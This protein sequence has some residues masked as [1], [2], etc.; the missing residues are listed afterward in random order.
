MILWTLTIFHSL[1][2]R[3]FLADLKLKASSSCSKRKNSAV[4]KWTSWRQRLLR[5]TQV[6]DFAN[7]QFWKYKYIMFLY[8]LSNFSFSG[9]M[10][11]SLFNT[12][13][14]TSA[15]CSTI[16]LHRKSNQPRTNTLFRS[17]SFLNAALRQLLSS[18]KNRK[19]RWLLGNQLNLK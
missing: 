8:V 11:Y 5:P 2:Y 4:I 12:W 6:R 7:T 15:P 3:M 13:S 17:F 1:A 14:K 10:N 9:S 18:S 16:A 19:S